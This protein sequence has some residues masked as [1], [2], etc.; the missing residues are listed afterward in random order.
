MSTRV[1]AVNSVNP[2]PPRQARAAAAGA[3][4]VCVVSM[5]VHAAHR[6]IAESG[7]RALRNLA[8]DAENKARNPQPY[9]L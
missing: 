8:T 9:T 2:S 6:S 3:V 1:S 7:C 5:S 4:E